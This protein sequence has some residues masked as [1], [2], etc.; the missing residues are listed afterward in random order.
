MG[1]RLPT[2]VCPTTHQPLRAAD[3]ALLAKLESRR[4]SGELR[5]ESGDAVE[6]ALVAGL[7]REDE[8]LL[9]P[10]REGIPILLA[11]ESIRVAEPEPET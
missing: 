10:V 2:I 8:T 9:Y 1:T 4:R 7:V 11:E 5:N 3:E 6:A